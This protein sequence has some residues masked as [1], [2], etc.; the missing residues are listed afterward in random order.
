M[1]VFRLLGW[2]LLVAAALILGLDL[3]NWGG[4]GPFTPTTA[5]EFWHAVHSSS[6]QLSQAAI[7]RHVWPPLW[8]GVVVVL[9]LP[10]A[11]VVGAL[12]L[13][14]VVLFRRRRKRRR[15]HY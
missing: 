3:A 15:L 8:D 9:G 1:I 12:G 14:L 6:L 11:A 2:V 5:G 7:Q 4:E 10:A 13:L